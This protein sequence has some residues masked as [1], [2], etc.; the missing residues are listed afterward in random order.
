MKPVALAL[1]AA[2]PLTAFAQALPPGHPPLAPAA[3]APAPAIVERTEDELMREL[4]SMPD[5]A[6]RDKPFEVAVSLGKLYYANGRFTEA[7]LYLG[8]A[9]QKGEPARLLWLEQSRRARAAKLDLP[10]A[11]EA[12]CAEETSELTARVQ[13]AADLGKAGKTGPAATCSRLAVRPVMEIRNMLA[14]AQFHA[15]EPEAALKTTEGTLQA[16]P[17]DPDALYFQ[18]SILFETRGDDLASL[19]RAK[20]GFERYGDL[21]PMTEKSRWTRKL[22]A[23]AEQGIAAGGLSKIAR[24]TPAPAPAP[25][26]APPPLSQETM[27]AF[28]KVE[29]TPELLA[30]LAQTVET[31]EGHL[32]KGR[33]DEALG[34]YKQV[35]P[36]QPENGRMRAGMAWA[37]VKLGKQPMAD[38]VWNVAVRGD[39]RAVDA[40]GQRLQSLG[41]AAGARALWSKLAQSDAEYARTSG[42]G[43]RLQ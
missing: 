27:Q 32:A 39:P 1:V 36:L 18:A 24:A 12:G 3:A 22:A 15:G 30:Q 43:S 37:L 4:D 19:R 25:V 7:A 29:R 34:A 33:F 21:R 42:L 10:T 8:Q 38:N 35:M 20:E 41:D 31:A 23:R 14:A 6:T 11:Q 2:L 13:R 9:A 17:D 5:L 40:L 16:T 26:H 28:E